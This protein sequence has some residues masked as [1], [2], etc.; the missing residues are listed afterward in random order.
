VPDEFT[1]NALV[2]KWQAIYG[3]GTSKDVLTINLDHT[4]V[5]SYSRTTDNYKFTISGNWWTE[6]KNQGL[7][8][9]HLKGMKLCNLI[10]DICS[11]ENGGGGETLFSDY[12]SELVTTME[13]EVILVFAD[14][15]KS[16]GLVDPLN[17]G[18]VL[19]HL[20]PDPDSVPS[21]FEMLSDAN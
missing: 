3:A 20:S 11:L 4:Y 2:G 13:N 10:E 12:C 5:Q 18:Y 15:S 14:F 1:E 9:L 21:Y 6:S 8:Y 16:N 7:I 17:R 19:L